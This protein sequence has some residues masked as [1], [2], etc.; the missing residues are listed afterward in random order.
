MWADPGGVSSGDVAITLVLRFE[1]VERVWRGVSGSVG[2]L[3]SS[4]TWVC[5]HLKESL[6]AAPGR[7]TVGS[8]GHRIRR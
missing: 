3:P 2:L 4:S 5:V 6:R 1:P 7:A 8:A